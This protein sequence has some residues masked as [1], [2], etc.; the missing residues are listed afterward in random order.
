MRKLLSSLTDTAV[1]AWRRRREP[2]P[3]PVAVQRVPHPGSD[4]A[5]PGDFHGRIVADYRP[6]TD[7]EPDPGEIVWT[8]VPFEEDYSQGKDRPVLV[9]ARDGEW[10]L[11]LPLSSKNH[12]LD[13][14]QEA[15]QGRYWA[16]IGRGPWDSGKH[17]SSV[18]VNRVV[19]VRPEA[20]RRIG[21]ILPQQH[22]DDVLA[23]VAKHYPGGLAR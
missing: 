23:G 20:V 13:R 10:F 11:A 12:E 17:A 14:E 6:D 8:W 15:S 5:Y 1:R 16:S 22:F 18:R 9:V 19:R 7:S 4:S 3:Q 21:G 2:A